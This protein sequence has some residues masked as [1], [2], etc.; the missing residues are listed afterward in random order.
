MLRSRLA[1]LAPV[2][3]ATALSVSV[4]SAGVDRWPSF[5][6]PSA[7]GVA[8]GQNL[9][10]TWNVTT[11]ENIRWKATVPGLAHSSP[12]VWGDRIF[13]TTRDQQPCRM[14]PSSPASTVR[15]PP[16]RIASPQRWV[17][18]ALD[19]KTGRTLWQQTAYE[20]VPREKRHIKAT[21]ANATPATDGRYVV[22]FF[23]SQGLYAFDIDGKAAVEEGP[24]CPQYRRLRSAGVRVG[25]RQLADHLQG[26]GDRAVRHAE[27]V[28]RARR[29]HRHREDRVEDVA[30]GAAVVGDADRLC[31]GVRRT[32]GT[33]D[34]RVELHP[35]LRS[36][37]RRGAVAA[38]RQL[39]DHR[40]DAGLR[41]RA[42]HRR[43]RAR[44]GAADLRDPAGG[45]ATSRPPAGAD[46]SAHVV[47]S[48][49]GRGSYMPTPLI[50]D[51]IVYVLA[52][53]GLLDAYD[54][55]TGRE[56]YRQRLEHRGS[57]FSASPVAADGR[58][59]LSSED[60]DIF[61]VQSGSR[62][63]APGQEPDGRAADGDAGDCRAARCTCE[64]SISCLPSVTPSPEPRGLSQQRVCRQQP[65]RPRHKRGKSGS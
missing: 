33:R 37:H 18:I 51:G 25:H 56:I 43:E 28:V 46:S 60:G 20:G 54:L 21:Y 63:R 57:G 22:A 17:V 32:R 47:W 49:T 27:R 50:Y 53:A 14:R 30:Q 10:D 5:R 4:G 26:P 65:Q 19:R 41:R 8:S 44:A 23:G 62:V 42:D 12:I 6:G 58:I 40:A 61:V 9:P 1:V 16:P 36:R 2:T 7:S 3:I 45:R 29:R 34:Q 38:G 24:G 48:K 64:G 52:N 13:V 31:V 15:A 35:R 39:E 55:A 11:G 59:Y